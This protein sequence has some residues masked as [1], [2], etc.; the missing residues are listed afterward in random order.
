M[1]LVSVNGYYT[2]KE[3]QGNLQLPLVGTAHLQKSSL[4]QVLPFLAQ[5]VSDS[6]LWQ[7]AHLKHFSCHH[8]FRT[9]VM[10]SSRIGVWHLAQIYGTKTQVE[11]VEL[12]HLTPTNIAFIYP[13]LQDNGMNSKS[14]DTLQSI[15]NGKVLSASS[16][17]SL[18]S[19]TSY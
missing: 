1:M 11:L 19:N 8:L 15:E 6:C 18:A 16:Y 9:E 14:S 4:Q 13:M 17:L 5:Q 3:H 2:I 10:N 12:R 7:S